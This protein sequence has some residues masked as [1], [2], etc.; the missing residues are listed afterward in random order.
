MEQNHGF[1]ALGPETGNLTR[2]D[3]ERSLI[4]ISIY[5]NST[6]VD[7]RTGASDEIHGRQNHFVAVAYT[8]RT[9][10]DIERG[11]TAVCE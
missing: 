3:V 11:G 8:Q 1:C 2:Q 10:G 7:N 5:W 4:N 6:R 9:Q